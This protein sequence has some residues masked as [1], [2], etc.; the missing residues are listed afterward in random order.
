MLIFIFRVCNLLREMRNNKIIT[1]LAV[2]T[3]PFSSLLAFQSYTADFSNNNGGFT[4]MNN[5]NTTSGVSG[6]EFVSSNGQGGGVSLDVVDALNLSGGVL[7]ANPLYFDF[8]VLVPVFDPTK[9][10]ELGLYYG[11]PSN[12]ASSSS[13]LNGQD[14]NGFT[15]YFNDGSLY[16]LQKNAPVQLIMTGLSVDQEVNI[17][18]ELEALPG[19]NSGQYNQ[20]A[21]VNVQTTSGTIQSSGPFS[22]AGAQNVQANDINNYTF[23]AVATAAGSGVLTDFTAS[24]L[25]ITVPEPGVS[26]FLLGALTFGVSRRRR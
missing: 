14:V 18:V 7:L 17:Q 11:R 10:D 22:L 4:T 19:Q 16:G 26:L 13:V 9:N 1:V 20:S 24:T 8:S 3:T 12:Q 23:N 2:L 6:L 5:T 15:L 21:V 25:P